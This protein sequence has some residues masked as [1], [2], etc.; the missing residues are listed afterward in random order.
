MNTF[1]VWLTDVVE[2]TGLHPYFYLLKTGVQVVEIL[3]K[4]HMNQ[5]IS[6]SGKYWVR[7]ISQT[8]SISRLRD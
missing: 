6:E 4:F 3:K 8:S 7:N 1:K 2:Q 5:Y